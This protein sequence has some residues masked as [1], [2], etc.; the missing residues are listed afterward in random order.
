MLNR[1]QSVLLVVDLQDKVMP[2]DEEVRE[3]VFI[4]AMR[5]MKAAA[6]LNVPVMLT[7]Q[8]PGKLG[9]TNERITS[10]LEKGRPI[11]KMEFGALGNEAVRDA[12]AHTGRKQ[13]VLV[14]VETHVCVLQSALGALELGYTP[15]VVR[16]AI[17]SR[18]EEEHDA[19]IARMREDGV[20]IVTVEMA[21]FEW[22]RA[23]GTDVFRKVLPLL[24]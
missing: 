14:G 13:L 4:N 3:R 1:T 8:N 6:L 22:L 2:G 11:P 20:G 12:I 10:L 15:Y 21:L 17:A 19:G 23:A 16:D 5:M 7:E 9:K 18:N 24:K